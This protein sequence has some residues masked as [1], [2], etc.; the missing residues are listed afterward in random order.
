MSHSQVKVKLEERLLSWHRNI[1]DYTTMGWQHYVMCIMILKM[2]TLPMSE[3]MVNGLGLVP[4]V[5]ARQRQF[6]F[7]KM[8]HSMGTFSCFRVFM[9][10]SKK[11]MAV[12]N[13]HR[14]TIDS[15]VPSHVIKRRSKLPDW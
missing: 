3:G 11:L 5:E 9:M 14:M 12:I 6:I 7:L 10:D 2:L 8:V 4:L 15:K 13:R 1:A